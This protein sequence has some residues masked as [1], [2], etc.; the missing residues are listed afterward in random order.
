MKL[1]D[2]KTVIGVYQTEFGIG[3]DVR[4]NMLTDDEV[5]RAVERFKQHHKD[6]LLTIVY[7]NGRE[8]YRE[9]LK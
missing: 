1:C 5:K 4:A 6:K 8:S 7:V 2:S 3:H 9:F